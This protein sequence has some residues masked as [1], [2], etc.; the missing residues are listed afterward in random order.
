FARF[1]LMFFA[2]PVIALRRICDTLVPGGRLCATVWRRREDNDFLYAAQAIV[3]SMLGKPDR[4]KAITCGPG[5]FSMASADLVT[6][7]LLAAG[8]SHVELARSDADVKMGDT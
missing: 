4:E 6:S 7:Q 2:Q 1:G 8:F 5:P 3:E